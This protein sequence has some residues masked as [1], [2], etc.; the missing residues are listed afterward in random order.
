[1]GSPEPQRWLNHFDLYPCSNWR[2][3]GAAALGVR[4][5][6]CEVQMKDVFFSLGIIL[7][8]LLGVWNIVNNYR[9]SRRTTFIKTVTSERVKWI[10]KLRD[11]ISTFCGLTYTWSMSGLEGK[12]EAAEFLKQIDK[13]RHL[14]RLQLNPDGKLDA[15]IESLIERIP[16]L[17]HET[18][19][20]DLKTAL[21]DL[22]VASQKLLKEEWEK[23][24]EESMRGNLKHELLDS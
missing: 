9:T 8:F 6:E 20:A 22:V 16:D 2:H 21:N 23:V 19:A 17:T 15:E 11:N 18:Q 5:E 10:E 12:P 24:K 7:T 4:N 14:I 3:R 13:L 1:L